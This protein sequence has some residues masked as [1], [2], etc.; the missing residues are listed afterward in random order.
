MIT[1]FDKNGVAKRLKKRFNESVRN[2]DYED[3]LD[4]LLKYADE[5][6]YADFHLTCGTLYLLMTQDSDDDE[7]LTL[8]FREFM[9]HIARFPKCTVAYRNL[10]AVEF[11]RDDTRGAL[12]VCAAINRHGLDL[13]FVLTEL[14][15]AQLL[16][17]SPDA[18]ANIDM[19]LAPGDFGGIDEFYEEKEP[20][21]YVA[22]PSYAQSANGMTDGAEK[23]DDS[24]GNFVRDKFVDVL[25]GGDGS[26]GKDKVLRFRGGAEKENAVRNNGERVIRFGESEA[27][28]RELSELRGFL[29]KLGV[30]YEFADDPDDEYSDDEESDD[31]IGKLIDEI[32]FIVSDDYADDELS[33]PVRAYDEFDES[34]DLTRAANDGVSVRPDGTDS[35][36]HSAMIYLGENNPDAALKDLDKIDSNSDK[37]YFVLAVRGM[38]FYA[39]GKESEA[40]S[41]YLR[42]I[43]MHPDRA[44]AN[45]M[46]CELY[47]KQGKFERIP[48]LLSNI[49]EA[50]FPNAEAVYKAYRLALK[51][52]A[53]KDAIELI[54]GYIDEF[55][56]FEMRAVYAQL[57]YNDGRKE[58]ATDEL[59]KLTRIFYDDLNTSFFYFTAKLG[60]EKMPLETEAPQEIVAVLVEHI[61]DTVNG[62]NITEDVFDDVATAYGLEFF[63][64][65]EFRNDWRVV[66]RMFDTV[67]LLAKN[68]YTEGKM[69]DALVSPYVEPIVKAVILSELLAKSHTEKF[70]TELSYRPIFSEAIAPPDGMSEGF[71]RAWAFVSMLGGDLKA[72]LAEASLLK[73]ARERGDV[74]DTSAEQEAYYLVRRVVEREKKLDER[75]VYA[76]GLDTKAGAN[77]KFEELAGAV[78]R[79]KSS[80]NQPKET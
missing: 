52:C 53:P 39:A 66:K 45:L 24:Y 80:K 77:R 57:L 20:K 49:D 5:T 65:L 40:E 61:M 62:G 58:E 78:F 28:E 19:L 4:V 6:E 3:A 18:P 54:A 27:K 69:R 16:F 8:A 79:G 26:V 68:K 70:V 23:S 14:A 43:D 34:W 63:I 47:E 50:D 11:L 59:Y 9:L 51:Y 55:N 30:D 31:T 2:C 76:L 64:T 10:L 56:I 33:R 71:Y 42:A 46:L 25:N 1:E 48:H 74:S 44:L 7:L 60:V 17:I 13:E 73:L 32:M 72:L 22:P 37:Y 67:R 12:S 75:V 35:A 29:D 41:E 38:I 15:Q 36:I 21:G